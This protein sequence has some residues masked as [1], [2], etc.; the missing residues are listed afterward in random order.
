MFDSF[1]MF[2]YR[3]F[4]AETAVAK[5][6]SIY[7]LFQAVSLTLY[8]HRLVHFAC[9]L[10]HFVSASG[11]IAPWTAAPIRERANLN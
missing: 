1:F 4:A 5:L 10:L 9:K 11:E 8:I 2:H 7:K 3:C 6:K